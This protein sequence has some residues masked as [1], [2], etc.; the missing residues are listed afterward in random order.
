MDEG[1]RKTNRGRS[2]MVGEM[3]L[4]QLLVTLRKNGVEEFH[5]GEI[6]VKFG[7]RASLAEPLVNN[8][9]DGIKFEPS[10]DIPSSNLPIDE[11]LLFHSAG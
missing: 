10:R 7:V 6:S 8:A 2:R 11:E 5:S 4:D 3:T 9:Q 1:R